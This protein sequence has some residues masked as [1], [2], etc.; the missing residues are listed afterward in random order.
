MARLE[1]AKERRRIK[2]EERTT[3]FVK[4]CRGKVNPAKTNEFAS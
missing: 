4:N 2:F 3:L 1:K